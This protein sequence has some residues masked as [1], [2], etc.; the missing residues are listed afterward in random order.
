MLSVWRRTNVPK[1]AMMAELKTKPSDANVDAFLQSIPDERKRQDSYVLLQL[2]QEVT[3]E[4]PRLWGDSIIGFG[5]YH[6]VYA[7]GREGDWFVTGFSPRKQNLTLY[8]MGGFEPHAELLAKLGKY[9]TG[10]G[11]LYINK[12]QD[13]DQTVLRS[14]MTASVDEAR[15]NASAPPA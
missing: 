11:C 5:D 3:G 12:L 9:K 13:V 4:T 15:K 1:E 2:L 10:K 8:V 7:S 6:Y 14:L